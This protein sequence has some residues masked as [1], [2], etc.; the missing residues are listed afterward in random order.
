[1]FLPRPVITCSGKKRAKSPAP[2]ECDGGGKFRI[3]A[4]AIGGVN[5]RVDFGV[6]K[7]VKAQSLFYRE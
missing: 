4:I 1:V 3:H 6:S 7:R 5:C 2:C